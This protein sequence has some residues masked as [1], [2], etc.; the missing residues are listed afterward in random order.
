M[1]T[2]GNKDAKLIGIDRLWEERYLTR[3]KV[4]RCLRYTSAKPYRE[5][6]DPLSENYSDVEDRL[7]AAYVA[8]EHDQG[9]DGDDPAQVSG[10]NFSTR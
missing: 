4:G 5:A 2:P 6:N 7:R 9:G 10:R 8:G 1:A 3:E